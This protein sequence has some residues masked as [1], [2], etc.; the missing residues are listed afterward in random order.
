MVTFWQR[1]LM[2]GMAVLLGGA[3]SR[4]DFVGQKVELSFQLPSQTCEV[5]TTVLPSTGYSDSQ[6]AVNSCDAGLGVELTGSNLTLSEVLPF[7]ET[8]YGGSFTSPELLTLSDS[9]Y[10]DQI[11][12]SVS[13]DPAT[14]VAGFDASRVSFDKEDVYINVSG[15]SISDTSYFN[16]TQNVLISSQEISLDFTFG[17][18]P[19]VPEPRM[20]WIVSPIAM[21][22][23]WQRSV[24]R[25]RRRPSSASKA[26]SGTL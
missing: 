3:E 19:I 16:G 8:V 25:R 22:M 12:T 9:T 26:Q 5:F 7:V 20:I 17:P 11:I 10:S 13:V 18:R 23:L 15:L 14:D 21:A 2:A 6:S 4:A 24:N 1:Y